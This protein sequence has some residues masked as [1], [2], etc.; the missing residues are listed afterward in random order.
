MKFTSQITA[1]AISLGLLLAASAEDAVKFNVPG[2]AS[3]APQ[4]AAPAAS[5]P[6]VETPVVVPPKPKFTD[7]QLVEAYGWFTGMRMGLSQLGFTKTE[8]EAMNRGMQDAASGAKPSFDPKELGPELQA[9]LGKKNE[10][11]LTRMRTENLAQGTA[12]F[13]KLKENKSVVELPSGLRYE[14]VKAGAGAFPKSTDTVKV[15]YTGTLIDGT[16]FDSSVQRGQPAEFQLNQVIP[17]W[18]EGIQKIAVGG[19][20]KLYIPPSLAYGDQG[21]QAIPPASTLIFD[22]EVLEAKA[23]PAAPVETAPVVPAPK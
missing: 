6:A 11:Y 19:K 13:T 10:V 8:V 22:V 23:A 2:V 14:I 21:N 5:Q 18:T 12:F 4:T 15:H 20:G 16:V 3:S 1:G 9:F 7:A 17:G